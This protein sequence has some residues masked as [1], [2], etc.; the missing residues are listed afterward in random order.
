MHHP[1]WFLVCIALPAA[2][3]AGDVYKCVTGSAV[4]YQSVPCGMGQIEAR[5]PKLPEYA[6]PPERD[7]AAAPASS[8]DSAS[9][10]DAPPA[11]P[12]TAS[13]SPPS[14][15]GFPFRTTIG[16]GMTDDQVLNTPGWGR[17]DR[18]L[19]TRES[20]R[21]HETWSYSRRAGARK[22]SFTNGKLTQIDSGTEIA[23]PLQV[24]SVTAR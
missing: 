13:E 11:S 17:P 23:V 8:P 10:P 16:L 19:Q 3:S 9:A 22:L 1:S 18:I 7:A 24:A 14:R 6:D 5:L 4:A 2:A 12:V 15:R 21:W 20:H